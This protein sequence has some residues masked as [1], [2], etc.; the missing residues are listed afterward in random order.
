MGNAKYAAKYQNSVDKITT[1]IQAQFKGGPE[2]AKA[3][4][5]MLLPMIGMPPFPVLPGANDTADPDGKFA[6][7]IWQTKASE[8]IKRSA[9]LR[10]TIRE[11]MLS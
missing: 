2:I 10:N 7:H 4:R 6:R 11:L 9:F 8:A 1:H 3:I 5:D